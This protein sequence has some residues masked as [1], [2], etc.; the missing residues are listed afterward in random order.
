MTSPT[1]ELRDVRKTYGDV[2]AVRGVTFEVPAGTIFGLLGPNGAGKTTTIRMIMDIIA[3][4]SGEVLVF[5]HRRTREDLRR[6]GYLPEERGLYR[7]MTVIDQLVYLGEL[8]GLKRRE[9]LPRIVDWLERVDLAAWGK[10][11]I[12]E[13][14]KGMQQKVQLVGTVLHEPDLLVLDEPFTG[15][16]PINQSLFRDLLLDYRRRGKTVVLSTHGML[17]AEK[18]CDHICLISAGEVVL[19]GELRAIRRRLGG[20]AYRLR[21]ANPQQLDLDRLAEVP[22]IERAVTEDSMVK[23][24]LAPDVDG[25]RVLRELVG[26]LDVEEFRSEEPD[27]EEIFIKAVSGAAV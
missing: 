17:L 16:D 23:L 6:I 2:A 8:R 14:S 25:G 22:G 4:D 10:R 27:L 18:L 11:K 24:L 3:P 13:L 26:F 1:L 19:A 21:V 5:G 12:E 7:K 9:S 20:N 15:L